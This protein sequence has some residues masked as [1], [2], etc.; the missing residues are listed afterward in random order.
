M[1][2]E[3]LAGWLEKLEGKID[4]IVVQTTKTNGRVNLI[5]SQLE[6]DK[7]AREQKKIGVGKILTY[8]IA[9][10]AIVVSYIK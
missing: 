6:S 9:I 10:S 3:D 2:N 8:A 1:T 5:E 7:I 4:G